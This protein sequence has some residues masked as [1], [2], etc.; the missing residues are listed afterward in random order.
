ML[1]RRY[2]FGA[3]YLGAF[4]AAGL[5]YAQLSPAAQARL[6]DRPFWRGAVRQLILGACAAAITYLIGVG[7]G[8][9]AAWAT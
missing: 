9:V 5:A 6:T 7:V 8:H 1:R 2:A 4:L 3:A